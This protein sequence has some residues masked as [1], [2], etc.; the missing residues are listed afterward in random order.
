[1]LFIY[2]ELLD[3]SGSAIEVPRIPTVYSIAQCPN[4]GFPPDWSFGRFVR[5]VGHVPLDFAHLP[6]LEKC[7]KVELDP[8]DSRMRMYIQQCMDS[9]PGCIN[10]VKIKLVNLI[11][12]S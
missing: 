3:E 11:D 6:D 2:A 5:V 10:K 4:V 9:L 12:S 7:Y 1:M 8:D